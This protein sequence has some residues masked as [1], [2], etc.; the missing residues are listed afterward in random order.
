MDTA[1]ADPLRELADSY[2]VDTEYYD[3]RGEHRIVSADSLRAVLAAFDVDAGSDASCAAAL[4]RRQADRLSV[5]LP[6]CLVVRA[7]RAHTVDVAA[8]EPRIEL[9]NGEVVEAA[10]TS[11]YVELPADLPTGYHRLVVV[12]AGE[13]HFC[14]LIVTPS[15]LA[16]PPQLAE[17]GWGLA[18]QLYSVRSRGSWEV[19]D[20]ADLAQLAAWSAREHSA[21]FVLVNPLHAAEV[22]A[23][24]NPS[25]Y[26]PTSRRFGNPV[27]LRIE[28][29][30]GYARL[31]A[32]RKAEVDA[33]G[34]QLA[35]R[36]SDDRLDRDAA[37]TAKLAALELVHDADL[38]ADLDDGR[39]A[40]FSAYCEREGAPLDRFATWCALSEQ[41]GPD[42]REWPAELRDPAS[43]A[44]AGFAAAHAD[45]VDFHRW[46]QWLL[47]EQL[48]AAQHAAADAGMRLGVIHDVAVGVSAGGADA[49]TYQDVLATGVR[50][51][52]PPDAYSQLGQDW[53]QPP[54]RPDRLAEL[55]Y[56]PLRELF[57]AAL[58]HA[59]GVRV[60]HIIGLFR[61][62]WIPAGKDALDGTYVRYDYDALVGILAL[63]AERAGAV[64][65]GEDLGNVEPWVRDYLSERGLLGTNI[66][67]FE[68]DHADGSPLRPQ[69]WRPNCLASVTTHDLPP[70]TGYLAGDHIRLRQR[71]GLLTRSADEELAAA[72]QERVAWRAE[73][74]R[75]GLLD[76]LDDDDD[77]GG[78]SNS[79]S[80]D[81]GDELSPE[82]LVI[83][84]HGFLSQTPA[85]LRCVALTDA[86]GERRTQNQPGTQ[87]EYPNWRIPLG[88]ADGT[89]ILL[90]DIERDPRVAEIIAATRG[91]RALD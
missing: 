7:G 54:W 60:D 67:W 57:A 1:A 77:D 65:I 62:W 51:G 13:R 56:A 55:C 34:E 61:L 32:D 37:W 53:Q 11:A 70:T 74:V 69:Q 24:M 19:G 9:E 3:W 36:R 73:L 75:A 91:D 85:L 64:I 18:C 58:R 29:V 25:P 10:A 84:L 38:D 52:A 66:L 45:R 80:G 31:A 23:P 15:R 88:R 48:T 8:V 17:P 12:V 14:E 59:G 6:P 86:V 4:E 44:V 27:Y 89:S 2:G 39:A 16:L 22:T 68:T 50:V 76:D 42:W 41:H 63:E 35:R 28:D 79:D 82:R 83:A 30:P 49:W 90:E 72:E 87:D 78:G 26:L 20:L 71:L 47:G 81:G 43:R 46:L 5:V 33:L 40:A 21:D